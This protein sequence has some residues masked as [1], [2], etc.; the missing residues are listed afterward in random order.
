MRYC[1]NRGLVFRTREDIIAYWEMRYCRNNVAVYECE[2]SIIAYWEMRYCR[3]LGD[4]ILLEG[5][6]Y[7]LLGNAL[8]PE[9]VRFVHGAQQDYSLLG[10]ALLPELISGA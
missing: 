8:L 3:N 4:A 5:L 10:N 6:H 9:L 2:S 7:S 1:R